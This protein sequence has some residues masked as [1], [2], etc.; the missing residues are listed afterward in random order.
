VAV[1][2]Q[3]AGELGHA[4]QPFRP[5]LDMAGRDVGHELPAQRELAARVGLV[6]DEP[7]GGALQ[8]RH[9]LVV[10]GDGHVEDGLE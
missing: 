1:L 8:H 7:Q 2:V 4:G 6:P 3:R 9:R 5:Q 10:T